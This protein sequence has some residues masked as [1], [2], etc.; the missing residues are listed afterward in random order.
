V[1]QEPRKKGLASNGELLQ[2][3]TGLRNI[4]VGILDDTNPLKMESDILS[5]ESYCSKSYGKLLKI[6]SLTK[7]WLTAH[8][9]ELTIDEL[10]QIVA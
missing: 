7:I 4:I 9:A 8:F 5:I 10:N 6:D 3:R 2:N 1:N